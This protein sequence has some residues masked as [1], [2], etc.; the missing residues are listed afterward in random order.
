PLSPRRLLI[1][2]EG[3]VLAGAVASGGAA[4]HDLLG[5]WPTRGTFLPPR[6][7]RFERPVDLSI[8][9]EAV[10]V[11]GSQRLVA[12][13]PNRLNKYRT[14]TGRLPS[15]VV[16]AIQAAPGR[17][18]IGTTHGLA[19]HD[20][21]RMHRLSRR[22]GIRRAH[23]TAL[24]LDAGGRV[25]AGTAQDGLFVYENRA[26]RQF[27]D[28][29]PS[30]Y[31]TCLTP[32]DG[33]GILVGLYSGGL[34]AADG[35]RLARVPLPP[36]LQSRP[37]RRLVRLSA[38]D[39]LA[40]T[41]DGL[42]R[43][44]DDAW[45]TVRLAGADPAEKLVKLIPYG[46]G[47]ALVLTAAGRLFRVA[48][49]EGRP[50]PAAGFGRID[51]AAVREGRLYVA[52]EGEVR[53]LDP[54][55]AVP[56]T[57][58]G[59]FA[60]PRNFV[61]PGP[62]VPP[63]WKHPRMRRVAGFLAISAMLL[64]GALTVRSGRWKMTGPQHAWR[65]LPL[66][67]AAAASA[68]FGLLFFAQDLGLVATTSSQLLWKPAIAVTALW[69]FIHW[70]RIIRYE[71]RLREDAFWLGVVLTLTASGAALWWGLG[72]L[73]LALCFCAVAGLFLGRALRGLRRG[74]WRGFKYWWGIAVFVFQLA[75]LLPPLAY[76]S[77]T[78]ARAAFGMRPTSPLVTGLPRVPGRVT[79]S[80]D[81]SHVAYVERSPGGGI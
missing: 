29:L 12:V 52:T 50:V 27:R 14:L 51:A 26:W 25:W 39:Y 6:L 36:R 60:D 1:L 2:A 24:A 73:V 62:D 18:W 53:R 48:G 32:A 22:A 34:Y 35:G 72:A 23:V 38:G 8:D 4:W 74:T 79:W 47:D 68:G 11:V 61:A 59:E 81:G 17:T 31:V 66:R 45:R 58:R 49:V 55:R 65:I 30:P 21:F 37:F 3:L 28:E 64:A 10:W 77:L 40:V 70:I 63:D 54:V 5:N 7:M 76:A 71:W 43:G 75:A 46:D 44:R 16:T 67:S 57:T 78:W 41:D 15:P 33:K 56:L 13:F 9:G 69:T 19:F 42:L 80:A 20:G